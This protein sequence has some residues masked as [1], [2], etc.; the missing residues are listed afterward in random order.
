MTLEPVRVMGAGVVVMSRA[1]E[2]LIYLVIYI[3][4]CVAFRM[5][6]ST[7]IIINL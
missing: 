1:L 6:T 3:A 4:I 7:R 2:V 5:L